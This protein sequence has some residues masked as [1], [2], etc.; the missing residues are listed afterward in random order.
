MTGTEEWPTR[1]AATSISKS[2]T[3]TSRKSII[4]NGYTVDKLN[5]KSWWGLGNIYLKQEKSDKA[6]KCFNYAA[7]IYKNS[8]F[9]RTYIG[10][11]LMHSKNCEI[12]A[13]EEFEKSHALNPNTPLNSFMRIQALTKLNRI[14]EA[15]E[16]LVKLIKKHPKEPALHIH[17]G[18]LMKRKGNQEEALKDFNR[19]L[20]LNPKDANMIKN[21]ID[22]DSYNNL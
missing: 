3:L 6:L 8:A 18:K 4:N 17:K 7:S 20:D 21:L 13:L 10:M 19:A 22:D 14:E 5:Y 12:K 1:S 9:V 2:R 11:A 16:L 15:L